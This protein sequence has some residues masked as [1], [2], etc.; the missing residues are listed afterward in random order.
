MFEKI[1]QVES[2]TGGRLLW[3]NAFISYRTEIVMSSSTTQF[4]AESRGQYKAKA[5]AAVSAKSPL[6]PSDDPTARSGRT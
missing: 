6:A 1:K 2:L 5:Y 3:L 4:S